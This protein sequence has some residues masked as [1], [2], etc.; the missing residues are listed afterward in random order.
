MIRTDYEIYH[1]T[2]PGLIKGFFT[3]HT[4]YLVL[5][6][7]LGHFSIAHK[8]PFIPSLLRAWSI[9]IYSADISPRAKIGRAFR[10][11]HSVGI[12]IGD[13]AQ[14]GDN[15]ECFQNVTIGGRDRELNERTMPKIGN[16]VT[17]FSGACVLGPIEIGDNV[18]IGANSVVINDVEKNTVVAGVP[19]K[20]IGDVDVPHS[21]RSI[22]R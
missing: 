17:V 11:A 21:L 8:I 19:A 22:K 15:F 6:Y 18:S 9:I 4:F 10:V 16:N 5:L 13:S 12:V 1:M 7:R 20:K 14:I 2:I 3:G